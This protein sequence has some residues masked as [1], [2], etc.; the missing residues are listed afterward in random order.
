[1]Y[2]LDTNILSQ[3]LRKRPR[4]N[5]IERL[6]QAP[7]D[8]IHASVVT[9]FEMHYGSRL[10]EDADR[11]WERIQIQIV[12]LVNWIPIDEAI[13]LRAGAVAAK[14]KR[15]GHPIGLA[16]CLIAASAIAHD[17]SLITENLKHFQQINGLKCESW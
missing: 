2:L 13:A 12:P 17:L 3:V 6:H 4:E 10:R 15:A 8:T 11:F 14:L 5:V 16:D 7:P 1:V 9:L